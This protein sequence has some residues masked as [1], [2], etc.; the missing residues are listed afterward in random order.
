MDACVMCERNVQKAGNLIK[1]Y[2][3]GGLAIFR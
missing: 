3:S 1:C 2:L